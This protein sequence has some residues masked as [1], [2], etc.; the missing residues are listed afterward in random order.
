MSA[1]ETD[2][3]SRTSHGGL[4]ARL[5]PLASTPGALRLL[6][7]S[8]IARLPLAML[9]IGMLVHAKHLTGT[10]TAAGIVEAAFAL[11]LAIGGPLLGRLVDRRGQASVLVASAVAAAALLLVLAVMPVGVPLPALVALAVGIG[12]AV[13]PVG[14][15]LRAL[16]PDL[17]EDEETLRAVYAVD[18]T[19]V[20]LTWILGPPLVL[21]LGAAWSTGGALAAAGLVVL[22]GTAVF[23][24]QPASRA[25]QPESTQKRPR[26]GALRT[27]A[28]R[29]LV[30]VLVAVGAVFGAVQ[31]GVAAA[32][33]GIGSTAAA[34][35]L[36]GIWGVGSLLGGLLAARHGGGA[37]TGLGLAVVLGALTAGHLSLAAAVGNAVAMAVVL[38]I[39]GAA[40]APTYAT[41]YAMVDKAAP[42]GTATEAFAWLATAISIGAS[43]GAAG[44]GGLADRYGPVAAFAFAGAAGAVAV[45]VTVLRARTLGSRVAR[46][47]LTTG[48]GSRLGSHATEQV[49][50]SAA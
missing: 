35:P 4:A 16:F 32:A 27:A 25:W 21:A 34:G 2:S 44:A 41:V 38:L 47:A 37:R 28:M 24:A 40:I 39:A 8:V 5:R 6:V 30:I 23:A 18:A 43:T 10:F 29:T 3:Y 50:A 31:I 22:V 42:S 49:A 12:L 20:E 46:P 26:G 13:P 11:S 36:L 19:A 1:H 48:G 17:I 9:S 15:C 33:D 45:L 14:A 7:I